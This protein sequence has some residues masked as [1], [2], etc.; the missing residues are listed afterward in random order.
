MSSLEPT[1]PDV[2]AFA[3]VNDAT[4]PPRPR[5]RRPLVELPEPVYQD[6][7]VTLYK[8]DCRRL[9]PFYLARHGQVDHVITDPP[10]SARVQDNS[11]SPVKVGGRLAAAT[12]TFRFKPMTRAFMRQIAPSLHQL[13]RRWCLVF[14]DDHLHLDWRRVLTR[15]AA[16]E[17][18]AMMV[19]WKNRGAPQVSGDRPAQWQEFIEVF[20]P[21]GKKRWN[22]GGRPGR[23]DATPE[24]WEDNKGVKP[25][26]LM[27]QI[28]SDFCRPGEIVLDPFAGLATTLLACKERGVR[29]VGFEQDARCIRTA[30]Q[31]LRQE[32]LPFEFNPAPPLRAPREGKTQLR[33]VDGSPAADAR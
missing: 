24:Q 4:P 8:G 10:F 14:S 15:G 9:L 25:L 31:R 21:P 27:R 6:D 33:L 28:V 16:F 23:Y 30:I 7:L 19:Y 12:R 5:G 22:G 20:H 2:E 13:C 32:T 29:A 11:R 18:I 26:S 1:L 17:H 3:A